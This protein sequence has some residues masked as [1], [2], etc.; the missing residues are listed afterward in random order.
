M[1]VVYVG[2]LVDTPDRDSSWIHEMERK[3]NVVVGFSTYKYHGSASSILGRVSRRL[4]LGPTY[5]RL[6][7]DLLALVEAEKPDWVHFRLPVE[8]GDST[9]RKIEGMGV[10][11]T[12]FFN[13]NPFSPEMPSF[14]YEVF[15]RAISSYSGHF[16]WRESNM[17]DFRRY[18][19][20][21]VEHCP[22]Y[23]DP[24]WF[25]NQD[26]RTVV[27]DACY[28]GHWENDDRI[29]F[30]EA[31]VDEGFDIEIRGG[32]WDGAIAQANLEQL[33]PITH[34]DR[35]EVADLYSTSM[36]SL[37]FFSKKNKDG[38]TRRPLEVVASGGVLVCERNSE[39]VTYFKDRKEAYF[40]SSP[41]ELIDIF[42]L[43]KN[44]PNQRESVR[45]A[46]MKRLAEDGHTIGERVAQIESFVS[47]KLGREFRQNSSEHQVEH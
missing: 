14:H 11:T 16:L 42:K 3:G 28:V 2:E 26:T 9:I 13:D 38:W 27:R 34:A 1:K 37:C 39:S 36:A 47:T 31:L 25:E 22:P 44:D 10:I 18:G 17:P 12:C 6:Q 33:L 8:V 15:K 41:D 46:G 40:F 43:L 20:K 32:M 21:Y 24:S 19:A 29:N 35:H 23:Y 5:K 30:V 7:K 45:K 4:N